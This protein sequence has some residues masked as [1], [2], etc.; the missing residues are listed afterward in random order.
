MPSENLKEWEKMKKLFA[1]ALSLI[2]TVSSV[3][4]GFAAVPVSTEQEVLVG[5][6]VEVGY[7]NK[8]SDDDYAA[9]LTYETSDFT[10]KY[11][12][13]ATVDMTKVTEKMNALI[14]ML[15]DEEDAKNAKISGYFDVTVTASGAIFRSLESFYDDANVA[16]ELSGDKAFEDVFVKPAKADVTMNAERSEITFRVNVKDGVVGTDIYNFVDDESLLGDE[17]TL[18]CLK[19]VRPTKESSYTVTGNVTGKAVL[20]KA[21][22]SK[23]IEVPFKFEEASAT[24]KVTKEE[25][26]SSSSSSSGS[27]RPSGMISSGSNSNTN[28]MLG[29]HTVDYVLGTGA[30]AIGAASTS[31]PEGT[32]INFPTNVSREGFVFA[33]WSVNGRPVSDTTYTVNGDTVITARWINVNVPAELNGDEHIA[34]IN[35]YPDG[36]VKPNAPITRE[37]V[38]AIFYRLLKDNSYSNVCTLADVSADA[39]S[40]DA[41]SAL[42]EKGYI[43]GYPDGTF[44]PTAY[45]S[46]A[47]F[48]TIA[49]KFSTIGSGTSAYY[50]DIK[51]HWAEAN[52]AKVADTAWVSGYEDGTFK[53][54]ATISR[55]EVIKIVNNI[56]VRYAD[57]DTVNVDGVVMYSDNYPSEWYYYDVLE[58]TNGHDYSRREDGYHEE[59]SAI[60]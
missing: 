4:V 28:S 36:T 29:K 49:S 14:A 9:R 21:D 13:K 8:L 25:K 2:L 57:A 1:L 56:L 54:D 58:A 44:R 3:A 37:E 35:G 7:N 23:V 26:S 55:A 5:A 10:E 43:N 31:V 42:A 38:A 51:G 60:K 15:N 11:D 41:I 30:V 53:P 17:I 18:V 52:I 47:E 22:D 27:S 12:L 46:R 50:A 24:L 45:I 16:F 59:W 34:Y 19:A 33:G 39:W 40:I 6:S 48:V 32:V 20:T